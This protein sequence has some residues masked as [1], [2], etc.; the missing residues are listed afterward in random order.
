MVGF[1][2]RFSPLV[3]KMVDLLENTKKPKAIVFTVNA[4]PVPQDHW[5]QDPVS[6]GG[7]IVGEACH[8]IDLLRHVAGCRIVKA[9]AIYMGDTTR[10]SAVLSLSFEDGSVGTINYFANGSKLFPKERLEVFVD[11][12]ILVLDNFRKLTGYGVNSLSKMSLWKQDKGQAACT[13]AFA[14][15]VARG[16]A[17]PIPFEEILEVAE[18]TLQLAEDSHQ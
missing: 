11:G 2:R 5:T 18:V 9:S 3:Q 17:S 4:G 13:K 6:G 8:F 7:R 10:D 1:N 14:E 12:K 15:A 16:A